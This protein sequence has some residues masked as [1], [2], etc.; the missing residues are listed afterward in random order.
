MKK[1]AFERRETKYII[2]N[3]QLADFLTDL[4]EHMEQDEY[5]R[6][7]IQSLYYDTDN[8]QMILH[9]MEKPVYKEKFRVRCYGL[10]HEDSMVFLEL[11]KKIDQVV[12]KRRIAVSYEAYQAWLSGGAFP[13]DKKQPQISRELAWV[14]Q[15]HPDL[16]PK[17]LISYERL[18]Y[19]GKEDAQFRVTFDQRI[20]YQGG[21]LDLTCVNNRALVA[22]E[23]GV[24]MEVK[25]LGAYPL[26]F[27]ALLNQ[28]QLKKSSFSKY[29]QTYQRHLW[30]KGAFYHVSKCIS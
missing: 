1:Y 25:A 22:P 12:Y 10:A 14:F 21:C 11:K 18:S 19:F 9:S 3:E 5:G 26:W 4:A 24:L 8:Y 17:V 2:P 16:K 6:H 13:M 20:S 29:A 27:V 28:Y 7:L 23:L 30:K 15:Q